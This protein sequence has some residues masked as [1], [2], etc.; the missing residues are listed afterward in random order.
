MIKRFLMKYFIG[1]AISLSCLGAWVY[2]QIFYPED[3]VGETI[4]VIISWVV[5]LA[6]NVGLIIHAGQW[7][8]RNKSSK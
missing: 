3:F 6:G 2:Y 4:P 7:W 5:V 8:S 1:F